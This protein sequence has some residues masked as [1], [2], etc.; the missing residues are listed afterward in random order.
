MVGVGLAAGCGSSGKSA[1]S[2]AGAGGLGQG[3][4]AG[5]D[6]RHLPYAPC[7]LDQRVG[8]FSIEL[9]ERYTSISGQVFDGVAPKDVPVEV[10]SDADCRLLRAPQPE[11]DPGCEPSTQACAEGNTCVPRP[12]AHDLG[13]VTITGMAVPLVLHANPVTQSYSNP[14]SPPLPQPGFAP[15]ADLRLASSGGDY[16]PIALRGWGVSALS[17]VQSPIPVRRGVPTE[18]AWEAPADAGPAR[19]HLEL[20][21]NHHGSNKSWIECDVADTG[22]ATLAVG[23]VD[24]L[25]G[26]GESGYPTLT[27]T[28][29]TATSAPIAPGCVELL[30]SSQSTSDVQLDDLV[31]CSSATDCNP[32]QT[33]RPYELYCE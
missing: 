33:C 11:C 26:A 1:G 7:A 16:A 20:N 8:Q 4:A 21:I 30:V 27:V 9:A 18:V 17:G 29:R 32:G 28:R 10:L 31:S 3:G 14:P 12:V 6:A 23:V 15:G 13:T 5:V 19:V 24:A 25:F 22:A 2:T